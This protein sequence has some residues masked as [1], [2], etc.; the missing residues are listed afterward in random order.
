MTRRNWTLGLAVAAAL[1]APVVPARAAAPTV[2]AGPAGP[3][4]PVVAARPA[5]PVTAARNP[6]HPDYRGTI[7]VVKT[8]ARTGRRLAGAVFELWVEYNA[9]RGLQTRGIHPDIEALGPCTTDA[10]GVC[11]WHGLTEN[12]YYVKEVATPAGYV[13][14][15][16]PVTGPIELGAGRYPPDRVTVPRTNE[17]AEPAQGGKGGRGGGRGEG[18]RDD[19]VLR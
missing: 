13:L 10:Y 17:R 7:R 8:D 3:A 15:K 18:D 6:A 11:A 5:A 16:R 9:T 1:A 4:G 14:P 19:D 2:P 12:A